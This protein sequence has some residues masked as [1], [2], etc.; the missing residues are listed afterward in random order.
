MWLTFA[1]IWWFLI[2]I[3]LVDV[4]RRT[5]KHSDLFCLTVLMLI[6]WYWR[7]NIAVL[8][9]SLI[10]LIAGFLIFYFNL[11]GAGDIKLMVVLTLAINTEYLMIFIFGILF[12]GGILAIFYLFYGCLT[13]IQRV[14]ER[15]LPYTIPIAVMGA[16]FVPLSVMGS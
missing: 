11:I 4:A 9:Y 10:F 1:L 16:F 13:D 8:G 3:M 2:K 15:G 5:V 12:L 7:N 14:K 6:T